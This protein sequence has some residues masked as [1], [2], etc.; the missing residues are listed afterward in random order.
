MKRRPLLY[1]LLIAGSLGRGAP[2]AG[3]EAKGKPDDEIAKAVAAR[4]GKTVLSKLAAKMKPGSWASF[5]SAKRPKDLMFVR[6]SRGQRFHIAG[7]TDDGKWDSRTGQFLYYGFR[8]ARKFIAYSEEKNEWRVIKKHFKWPLKTTMGHIYG[9][10]AFDGTK[11]IFYHYATHSKNVFGYDLAKGEWSELPALPFGKGDHGSSLEYFPELGGLVHHRSAGKGGVLH[12]YREK[13]KSW[14]ALGKTTVCGYHSMARYNPQL[15][16]LLIAGGNHSKKVVEKI[17]S[18]GKI[19]RLKDAPVE[20]NIR[21]DKLV[22]DPLSGRYLLFS[23]GVRRLD[24]FD[25]TTSSW[26]PVA[27][28]KR[29][30]DFGKHEL[31]VTASVPEY[32]VV[33]FVDKKIRLY[34]PRKIEA[35]GKDAGAGR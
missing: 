31:P 7:W 33:M 17:D 9:G 11:G 29:P 4:R 3:A 26:K 2:A 10:N 15:K 34:K 27:G 28:Y 1:F 30:A 22:V 25:S 24:E 12:L 20:V 16:E 5:S 23:S 21:G 32:G 19:T 13:T 35:A 14:S 8:Q 18:Q 6:N